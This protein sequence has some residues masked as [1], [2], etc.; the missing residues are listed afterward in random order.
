MKITSVKCEKVSEGSIVVTREGKVGKVDATAKTF[1]ITTTK[2]P[3]TVQWSAATT[4]V[5]VDAAGL[6]DKYV[7]VEATASAAGLQAR[8]ISLIKQ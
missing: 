4:F 7:R 1:V 6:G 3:L 2:E 8:K 5:D